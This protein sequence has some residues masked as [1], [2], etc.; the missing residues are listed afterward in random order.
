MTQRLLAPL[1]RAFG[2]VLG[3]DD[4]NLTVDFGGRLG[5]T[6]RR[7]LSPRNNFAVDLSQILSYPSRTQFGFELRP[8]AATSASFTYYWQAGVPAFTVGDIGSG[9]SGGV[10]SGVQPLSNRQGF[11]LNITRL[12]K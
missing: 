11:R 1:E 3:L 5:Y 9:Y 2:G 7:V 8:D 12:Y 4:L 10:L 6:V